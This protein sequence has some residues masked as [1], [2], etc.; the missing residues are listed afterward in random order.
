MLRRTALKDT[1][2][3]LFVVLLLLL[4]FLFLRALP[5]DD[6]NS[7]SDIDGAARR[8]VAT[9]P[10]TH[11]IRKAVG[12]LVLSRGLPPAASSSRKSRLTC[13]LWP[14]GN[15]TGTSDNV[16]MGVDSTKLS[17]INSACATLAL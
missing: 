16:S 6:A 1:K 11:R 7:V 3:V 13:W 12:P 4:L 9:L 17:T 14:L 10:A 15:Y 2:A 8:G 5:F